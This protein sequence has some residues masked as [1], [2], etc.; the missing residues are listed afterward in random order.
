LTV[1]QISISEF[2]AAYERGGITEV[3]VITVSGQQR[4]YG[5]TREGQASNPD[6]FIIVYAVIS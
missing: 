2:Q 5:K 6:Q 4:I 3:F 1:Q